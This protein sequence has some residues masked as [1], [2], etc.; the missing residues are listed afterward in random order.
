MVGDCPFFTFASVSE[1]PPEIGAIPVG[2]RPFDIGLLDA[3][4]C[5]ASRI[6]SKPASHFKG[7]K[8]ISV[9]KVHALSE[10]SYDLSVFGILW[11][12][13]PEP[14]IKPN[15]SF[16]HPICRDLQFIHQGL[17]LSLTESE[18]S[19][20]RFQFRSRYAFRIVLDNYSL[21]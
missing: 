21:G 17:K 9:R 8:K 4:I 11:I 1:E 6:I 3:T 20:V 7:V 15:P 14:L 13:L 18:F 2:P 12:F 10:M 5:E 16:R 19:P